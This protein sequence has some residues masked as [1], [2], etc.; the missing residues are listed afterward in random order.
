MSSAASTMVQAIR[1]ILLPLNGTETGSA[2]LATALLVARQFNAHV[3]AIHVR[4]DSREVAPL[5]GEGLSGAMVEEMMSAAERETAE[6]SRNVLADFERF[7]LDH[8]VPIGSGR[9][10]ADA[11]SARLS[12]ITGREDD[13]VAQQARLSDLAVVPHPDA[14]ELSS[15]DALHAV[16]FDSGRPV[17]VAPKR[18]PGTLGTRI[19]IAWNGSAESAQAVRD[20]LPW[21]VRAQFVRVLHSPDYQR[22]GPQA[23]DLLPYLALHGVA[24]DT[25]EFRPIDREVG[26][27]LLQG[28][29]DFGAD[30]MCQGAYS[31]SRLRQLIL[32]GVTRHVLEFADLPVLMCR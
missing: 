7:V 29:R 19:A 15:S 25:A 28:A 6:R 13:I 24:A 12:L 5:A 4:A 16:L 10:D 21:L 11:P 23:A 17:L 2:A 1:Q 27:G 20:C 8:A 9:F 31:H 3:T 30:L 26:A 22:R 18:E 14:A 32:G